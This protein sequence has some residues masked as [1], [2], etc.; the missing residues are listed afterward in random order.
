TYFFLDE[1]STISGF[2]YENGIT[3]ELVPGDVE[4]MF[5]MNV[6]DG[7]ESNGFTG[8]SMSIKVMGVDFDYTC[9][10]C[11][12]LTIDPVARTIDFDNVQVT[13]QG[14]AIGDLVLDGMVGWQ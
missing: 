8:I 1:F 13:G 3:G 2:E 11:A 14:N 4:N 10:P 5:V 9:A 7:L 12:G 6:I